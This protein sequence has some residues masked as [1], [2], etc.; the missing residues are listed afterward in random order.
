MD[1]TVKCKR[2]T[3]TKEIVLITIGVL[4]VAVAIHFFLVPSNLT[5]GGAGGLAI[6]LAHYLPFDVGPIYT[7]LNII[8]FLV[9][10]VFIGKDFGLKTVIVTLS[11]SGVVWLL[12]ILYPNPAPLSDN[13]FLIVFLGTIIQGAGVGIVLNQY[14]ST[15]GTDIIAKIFQKYFGLNLSIGCFIA[16]FV[17]VV[18]AG[19]AFGFELML[20]SV[21]GVLINSALIDIVIDGLNSSKLCY[22]NTSKVP[23]VC[24][25]IIKDLDRS[26]NLLNSRGA[27]SQQEFQLILTAINN[28]EFMRLK[29]FVH[30]IDPK[31]FVVVSSANEVLGE[32]WRKFI[33]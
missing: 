21:V 9:G 32:K 8:L 31:A 11:L 19:I 10:L 33:G 15:G 14:T 24:E 20:Y 1:V 2:T 5:T 28:R 29:E 23:E 6:V 22:I 3:T 16:D 27:Y 4:M 26:A 7:A 17:V 30:S 18:L 13:L 25:F 12:E